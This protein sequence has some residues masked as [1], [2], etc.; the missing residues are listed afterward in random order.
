MSETD[1]F[2]DVIGAQHGIFGD[3]CAGMCP[4]LSDHEAQRKVAS[5]E[6]VTVQFDCARCGSRKVMTVEWPELLALRAGVP[7][8]FAYQRAQGL[9]MRGAPLDWKWDGQEQVWWPDLPCSLCRKPL[10][11][12]LSPNEVQQNVDMAR[13][14]G[15]FSPQVEQACAQ[16]CSVA[17]QALRQQQG[18]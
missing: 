14:R 7:P 11:V 15:F 17:I 12:W 1:G 16:F 8:A 3:D 6:G 5:P 18:R 10:L 2:D 4:A 9:P 13:S